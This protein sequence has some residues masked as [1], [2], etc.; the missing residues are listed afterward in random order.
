MAT[1]Q[2]SIRSKVVMMT[3]ANQNSVYDNQ[4]LAAYATPTS[5]TLYNL[6]SCS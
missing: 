3:A 1:R 5:L 6:M 4:S 2:M